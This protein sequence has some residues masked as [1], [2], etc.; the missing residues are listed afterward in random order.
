[1][2][3]QIW[4]SK[5]D[6]ELRKHDP[7]RGP[8]SH[9]AFTLPPPQSTSAEARDSP[10]A[11]LSTL[12]DLRMKQ[13]QKQTAAVRA[14]QSEGYGQLLDVTE[15]EAMVRADTVLQTPYCPSGNSTVLPS[16]FFSCCSGILPAPWLGPC[17]FCYSSAFN[18]S[19]R[20]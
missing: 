4:A 12:R 16:G 9:P 1:M 13:L 11:E 14:A 2:R 8:S 5:R 3:D 20:I 17:L 10:D 6:E 18:R 7:S 15:D 19:T